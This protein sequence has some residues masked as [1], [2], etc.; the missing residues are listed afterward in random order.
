MKE[1]TEL[2]TWVF[3][4]GAYMSVS[5]LRDIGVI[6]EE[7]RVSRLS[8]FRLEIAPHANIERASESC[9]WGV[10]AAVNHEDMSRL[11]TGIPSLFDGHGFYPIAVLVFDRRENIIPALCYA[12]YDMQPERPDPGYVQGIAA[13]AEEY[14]LPADYVDTIRR[15]DR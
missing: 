6:P 4:Y 1:V 10:A 3:F 9:V 15:F 8:G 2:K 13:T 12:S 5:A 11:H 7:Y 14:R